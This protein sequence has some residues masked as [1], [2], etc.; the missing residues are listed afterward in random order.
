MSERAYLG[1]TDEQDWAIFYGDGTEDE[2]IILAVGRPFTPGDDIW[3][4][5]AELE[6]WAQENGY[7]LMPPKYSTRL[8]A[9]QDLI[10]P[11]IFDEI[12]GAQE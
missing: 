1:L 2:P 4:A 6:A 3:D 12:F 8:W 10:E 7:Y 5:V 9:L 11:E